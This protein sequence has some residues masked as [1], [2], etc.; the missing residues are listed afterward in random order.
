MPLTPRERLEAL[1]AHIQSGRNLDEIA[2]TEGNVT[3]R[4]LWRIDQLAN[5][6][7]YTKVSLLE[8]AGYQTPC[9]QDN[10]DEGEEEEREGEEE[11]HPLPIP[12]PLG[13]HLEILVLEHN[14]PEQ[15]LEGLRESL[16][17][18]LGTII[19][20]TFQLPESPVSD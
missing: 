15:S 13:T 11:E 19:E 7:F 16:D 18:H 8:D 6:E 1:I 20:A 17:E 9:F 4:Q 10:P 3:Y 5:P 2:F 12:D 14:S